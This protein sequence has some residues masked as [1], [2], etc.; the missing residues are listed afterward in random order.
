MNKAVNDLFE[1]YEFTQNEIAVSR[2]CWKTAFLVASGSSLMS[3]ALVT[4][5]CNNFYIYI[6]NNE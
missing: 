3:F 4:T 5:Y 6:V 1:K 2:S